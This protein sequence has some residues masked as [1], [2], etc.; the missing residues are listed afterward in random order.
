M[1]SDMDVAGFGID[2]E[3]EFGVAKSASEVVD[4]KEGYECRMGWLLLFKLGVVVL[5]GCGG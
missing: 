3:L 1:D 4:E 2:I 5:E